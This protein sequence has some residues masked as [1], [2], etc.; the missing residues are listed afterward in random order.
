ML[1]ALST[2]LMGM[3]TRQ[4]YRRQGAASQL[5]Q[6]GVDRAREDGVPAF[7]EASVGGKPVYEAGG[8]QEICEAVPWDM[9]PY[10]VDLV[11]QIAKMAWYPSSG[12]GS[13]E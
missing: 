8:F 6:W 12:S 3:V 11:F 13:D 5:V 10:G 1:I 2:V 4:C 9:R 7:L